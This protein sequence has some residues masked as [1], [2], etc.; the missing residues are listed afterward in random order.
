[1]PR[2][3][4]H[5]SRELAQLVSWAV[6]EGQAL[7]V[8]ANGTKRGLG[9]PVDA[10]H[11]L[12]TTGFAGVRSYEPEE[13]VLTAGP[14]TP[15]AEIER[16]LD[17]SQQ[18]LAFEPGD[19]GPLM[20]AAPKQQTL[21]G[22]LLCNLAGPRRPKQGAARDHLGY[23]YRSGCG[24]RGRIQHVNHPWRVGEHEIMHQRAVVQYSLRTDAG[25]MR[26]QVTDAQLRAV[27]SAFLKIAPLQQ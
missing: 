5:D 9:R 16:L 13:L 11:V 4:P 23:R 8:V 19:W 18:M 17:Q 6:A 24:G 10:P 26:L 25:R 1:M 7:E 15:L 12:D 20:G 22:V 2:F 3:R 21:G 14:A 27:F